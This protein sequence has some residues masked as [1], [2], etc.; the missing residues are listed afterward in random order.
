MREN[1]VIFFFEL[2]VFEYLCYNEVDDLLE[3]L[4]I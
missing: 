4:I 3:I 2:D 1:K